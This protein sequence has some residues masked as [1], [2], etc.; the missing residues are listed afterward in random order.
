M[1]VTVAICT[2]NRSHLLAQTLDSILAVPVPPS[3]EVE[4][5][6][7][8]NNST[9]GTSEVL[10]RYAATGRIQSVVEPRQGLSHARNTALNAAK[11]DLIAWIDDDVRVGHQWLT[12]LVR[13]AHE[14]PQAGGFGGLITPWF[15]QAP[16]PDLVYAF[17]ELA[18]GFCG[19]D[20]GSVTRL[21]HHDEY[22]WGANMAFR[23]QQI[24]AVRFDPDYGVSGMANR[25]GG[26]EVLFIDALRG[27]GV[28]LAW[29]PDMCVQHYVSPHRMTLEYLREYTI[30]LGRFRWRR[31]LIQ[32]GGAQRILHVPRWLLRRAV[33]LRI[34]S[35]KYRCTGRRRDALSQY[36][37]FLLHLGMIRAAR[38]RR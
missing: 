37:D 9:D 22:V 19:L 29:V 30:E 21:L 6:V 5:L 25:G 4:V 31:G 14:M 36:R 12:A 11:G 27:A 28:Q 7:V 26:E 13:A 24:G 34:S 23:R 16:D 32:D 2:Y 35:L 10:A 15:V 1:N 3:V 17:P 20:L 38:E 8:D 33:H 18:R